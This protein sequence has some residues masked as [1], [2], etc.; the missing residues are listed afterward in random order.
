MAT[1]SG[2]DAQ[3]AVVNEATVGT[4][5]ATPS[6]RFFPFNS[7]EL[8]WDPSYID[9][10]GIVAGKRFKDVSQ[11]GISRKSASGKMQLPIM[12]KGM[13]FWMKHIL[14]STTTTAT[15]VGASTAME[16]VHTPS[17]LR[18]TSFSAQI[19]K[20]EPGS[21]IVQ[22]RTY[23]GCKLTDWTITIADNAIHLLD[24]TVDGWDEAT[25][26]A[27]ATATYPT[28]NQAFT[29]ANVTSFTTG[30]TVGVTGGKMAITGGTA[31]PSVITKMTLKGKA[32]LETT[33]YGLGNAGTKREQLESDFF[34]LT[35]TFDGEFDVTTWEGV[36]KTNTTVPLQITTTLGDAGGGNPY[37]FDILIPAAKITSAQAPVSD[38][39]L[40]AVSGEFTVYDPNVSG[41]SPLQIRI[42]STDSTP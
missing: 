17:G 20:P 42:V 9:N 7:A 5:P 13:G 36:N 12:T 15:A 14:G 19:G 33:R 3:L 29:F 11:V 31:V 39:G 1:G 4:T 16:Q 40:V 2:L 32:S 21:G 24:M 34:E 26:P 22:P 38:A 30:G 25:V 23:N 28:G 41:Q 10:P 18:G 8:V 35:G 37:T 27:L 6:W